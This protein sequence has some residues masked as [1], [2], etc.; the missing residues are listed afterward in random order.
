MLF[1][2][3]GIVQAGK[4]A[5]AD[6][7]TYLPQIGLFLA[8]AWPLAGWA[9]EHAHR[10]VV[11]AVVTGSVATILAVVAYRQT[12]CWRDS[13]ALWRQTLASTEENDV[14]HNNLANTLQR[15]GQSEEALEHYR[16]AVRLNPDY[17]FAHSNLAQLLFA[18]GKKDEAIAQYQ[19]AVRSDPSS[20]PIRIRFG[21]DLFQLGQVPAAV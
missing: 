19:E 2:V 14:A 16:E 5:Y 12:G 4:I 20:T 13:E 10:R 1:P 8:V 17:A 7:Y 18:Q 21:I 11:L 15:K 6:R 3:I 9:R